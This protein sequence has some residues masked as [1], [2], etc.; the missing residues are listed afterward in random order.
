MR[1]T[2]ISLLVVLATC[3]S[4]FSQE[5]L[6]VIS[7]NIW[8][9]FDWGKDTIRHQ[10]VINWIDAQKPDVVAL[11]ELNAY[12]REKLLMDARTWG[13]SYAEILKTSGYSVGITSNH[14]IEVKERIM[15]NMHHGALHCHTRGIDFFVVHL[16]PFSYEKRKQEA[17]ILFS[18]MAEI[19]E[20]Q[21]KV[22]VLGDF[23]AVSPFDA[24]LY[25][26]NEAMMKAL[27]GSDEAHDHVRNL[28]HDELEFGVLSSFLGYPLID[29]VQRY[30]KGLDQRISFP[31]QVFEKSE[32]EGRRFDSS[33]IDY[34]LVSPSLGASCTGARVVNDQP[35]Y[36]LSDHYPVV[37]EFKY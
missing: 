18:R 17:G 29:V 34:I 27:R 8:N 16:S 36:Y 33:R 26:D 32:G 31:S 3:S 10:K 6:K 30:T 14:P 15:E 28:F 11:Q 37:A 21:D 13:H 2:L 20:Q 4:I 25:R 1:K 23:N 22:I 9:G 24:D 35:A 19:S 12:T 7:Y 5:H